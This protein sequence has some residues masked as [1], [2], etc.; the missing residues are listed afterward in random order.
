MIVQK[1][2]A[3][4]SSSDF[5]AKKFVKTDFQKLGLDGAYRTACAR[6]F[7]KEFALSNNMSWYMKKL[8]NRFRLRFH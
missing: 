4:I 5:T 7:S 2:K 3:H 8:H 6:H 1:M